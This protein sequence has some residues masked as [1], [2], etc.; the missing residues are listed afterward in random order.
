MEKSVLI[1]SASNIW[2]YQSTLPG[3][4]QEKS[5]VGIPLNAMGMLQLSLGTKEYI[6]KFLRESCST[7]DYFSGCLSQNG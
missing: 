7:A 5:E 3:S 4:L 1:I 6:G 2:L